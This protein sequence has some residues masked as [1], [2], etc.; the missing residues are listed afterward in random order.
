MCAVR[1]E[2]SY[3]SFMNA[4][5]PVQRQTSATALGNFTSSSVLKSFTVV[6]SSL[7]VLESCP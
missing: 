7:T 6:P 2:N 1:R 4:L 3:M 5:S